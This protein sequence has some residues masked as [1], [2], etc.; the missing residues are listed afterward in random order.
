MQGRPQK[1]SLAHLLGI[2]PRCLVVSLAQDV[3]RW[4]NRVFDERLVPK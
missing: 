3:V 4:H 2:C 1:Q